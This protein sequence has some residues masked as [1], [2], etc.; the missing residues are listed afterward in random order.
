MY[1]LRALRVAWFRI[2]FC[3]FMVCFLAA[4]NTVVPVVKN[5]TRGAHQLA[6][7]GVSFG[8]RLHVTADCGCRNGGPLVGEGGACLGF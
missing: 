1:D 8:R 6:C 7:Q 3:F 2:L 5:N 4:L